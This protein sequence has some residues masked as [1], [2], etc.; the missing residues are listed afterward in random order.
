ML[1]NELQRQRQEFE[2]A[3]QRQQQELA[4]LRALMGRK[5]RR[6]RYHVSV[7]DA[8]EETSRALLKAPLRKLE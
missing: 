4:D 1:L 3:L 8:S 5:A 6:L 7:T 2:R